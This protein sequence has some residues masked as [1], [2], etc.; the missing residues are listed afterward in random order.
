[1]TENTEVYALCHCANF[2]FI[3]LQNFLQEKERCIAYRNVLHVEWKTGHVY[4]FDFGV[5]VFWQLNGSQRTDFINKIQKF[6]V[7]PLTT[8]IEDTFT[9]ESGSEKIYIKNDHIYLSHEDNMNLL[10]IS[11]GIAQSTK[12]SQF[13]YRIQETINE[14]SHIPRNIAE[15]GNSKLSRSDLAKLRGSLFLSKSDIMLNYDLL[16]T[17]DFFWDY[18]ELSSYYMI[19][20]DYLE[21][22]Q[23]MEV[24]SKKLET[25][26]ELF[27]MIADELRHK[28]SSM[29]EWI[30]IW[31]I[32]FEIVVFLVHDIFKWL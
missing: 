18:P 22:K 27:N 17:P 12:L 10:A 26:H 3:P 19:I 25:I 28:H 21:V 29:L 2:D 23:R 24:L 32:A 11:H 9:F 16:D 20:T 6:A 14:N 8:L 15:S 31:L 30:I 7:T 1:M 5:L 13:E 4:I